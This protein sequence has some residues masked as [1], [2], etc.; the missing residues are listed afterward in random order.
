MEYHSTDRLF[1]FYYLHYGLHLFIISQ[2]LALPTQLNSEFNFSLLENHSFLPAIPFSS[3]TFSPQTLQAPPLNSHSLQP[4]VLP[5][6]TSK[7][8]PFNPFSKPTFFLI[9]PFTFSSNTMPTP[10]AVPTNLPAS[11]L[12]NSTPVANAAPESAPSLPE[13]VNWRI[14]FND[15]RRVPVIQYILSKLIQLCPSIPQD[16]LRDRARFYEAAQYA[17]ASTKSTY[18]KVIA[19]N[20]E[21]LA[22]ASVIAHAKQLSRQSTATALLAPHG[23]ANFAQGYTSPVPQT[24]HPSQTPMQSSLQQPHASANTISQPFL[25]QTL[26]AT[27]RDPTVPVLQSTVLPNANNNLSVPTSNLAQHP[28]TLAISN[29]QTV[30]VTKVR[31]LKPITWLSHLNLSVY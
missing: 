6:F 3:F 7:P 20:I 8:H 2:I 12:P 24:A 16:F 26:F 25:N 15:E 21:R 14:A 29:R 5:R 10:P 9:T 31:F 22:R 30:G 11:S 17:Q 19:D 1:I 18:L 23:T 13:D 28:S 27:P 4:C